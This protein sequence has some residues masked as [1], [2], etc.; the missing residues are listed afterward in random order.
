LAVLATISEV[1][2]VHEA[3]MNA[4]STHSKASDHEPIFMHLLSIHYEPLS[5]MPLSDITCPEFPKCQ[6][7][8]LHAELT[9]LRELGNALSGFPDVL[10]PKMK[11]IAKLLPIEGL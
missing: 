8:Y 10:S 5:S 1:S 11:R 9:N 4:S 6:F 2:E 7:K 3:F